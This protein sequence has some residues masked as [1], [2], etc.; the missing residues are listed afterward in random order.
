MTIGDKCRIVND[1]LPQKAKSKKV[2]IIKFQKNGALK[3]AQIRWL[4]NIDYTEEYGTI[5]PIGE[6]RKI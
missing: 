1:W 2:Q 5:F 6:L 4:G 3:Y